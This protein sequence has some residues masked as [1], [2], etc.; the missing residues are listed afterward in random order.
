MNILLYD[1]QVFIPPHLDLEAVEA[2]FNTFKTILGKVIERP[3]LL[4]IFFQEIVPHICFPVMIK[5]TEFKWSK[6]SMAESSFN[7]KLMELLTL[8][9]KLDISGEESASSK[10]RNSLITATKEELLAQHKNL[11]ALK[12]YLSYFPYANL[13]VFMICQLWSDIE[14]LRTDLDK[15]HKPPVLNL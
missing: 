13:Y 3:I 10:K 4:G 11:M 1:W 7:Q 14:A 2:H 15:Y 8:H 12:R 5:F 6:S 9:S